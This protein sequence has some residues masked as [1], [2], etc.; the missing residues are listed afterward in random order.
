MFERARRG[1]DA[2]ETTSG[3]C[4]IVNKASDFIVALN[5]AQYAGGEHCFKMITITVN[6]KSTQ[7]QITDE[8]CFSSWS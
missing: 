8:V 6:G 1:R 2:D 7:A 5:S 3:A 4:G